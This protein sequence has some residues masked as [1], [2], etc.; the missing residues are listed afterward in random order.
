M[1]EKLLPFFSGHPNRFIFSSAA[2]DST[3]SLFDIYHYNM[4]KCITFAVMLIINVYLTE[5]PHKHALRTYF[6]VLQL[7]GQRHVAA[8]PEWLVLG[9]IYERFQD[10]FYHPA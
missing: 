7:F 4:A 8:F 3:E 10:G 6:F 5:I 2:W 1:L 9:Y